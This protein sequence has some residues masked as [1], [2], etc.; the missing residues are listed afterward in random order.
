MNP[1]TVLIAAMSAA[2]LT[3]CGATQ[4][5][6]AKP[7][8]S[9][10]FVQPGPGTASASAP[11]NVVLNAQFGQPYAVS[12]PTYSNGAEGPPDTY[13]VTVAAPTV[14]LSSISKTTY[15]HFLSFKVTLKATSEG[16]STNPL[17]FYVRGADGQH[18][19]GGSTGEDTLG[20]AA[21]HTGQTY[22]G[23]VIVDVPTLHGVLAYDPIQPGAG[24]SLVEWPF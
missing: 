5:G 17:Y 16:V 11:S 20:S 21:M 13:T 12:I 24:G 14:Y 22:S 1:R 6:S 15:S 3:A 9:D 7:A 10:S 19:K 2:V 18:Y 4:T 23:T 8:S